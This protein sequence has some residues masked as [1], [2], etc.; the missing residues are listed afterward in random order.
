MSVDPQHLAKIPGVVV[1]A[2]TPHGGVGGGE[3]GRR[4]PGSG[5]T[6]EL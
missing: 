4:R 2:C 5:Q 3:R 6:G 1:R